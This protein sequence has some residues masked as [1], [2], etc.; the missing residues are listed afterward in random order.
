MKFRKKK[1]NKLQLYSQNINPP[2]YRLLPTRYS[3]SNP[4]HSTFF[5]Q[6]LLTEAEISQETNKITY[7]YTHKIYNHLVHLLLFTGFFSPA[8]RVRIL[9]TARLSAK[10]NIYNWLTESKIAGARILITGPYFSQT[11]LTHTLSEETC[12]SNLILVIF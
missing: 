11:L 2:V 12:E 8:E 4:D 3:G 7:S 1:L 10:Q 9:I 6:T 5:S